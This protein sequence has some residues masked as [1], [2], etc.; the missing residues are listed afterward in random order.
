MKTGNIESRDNV[1]YCVFYGKNQPEK[2][3]IASVEEISKIREWL[4]EAEQIR[5]VEKNEKLPIIDFRK[6]VI[7]LING[8]SAQFF[9]L[10][11]NN[12][13]F[14]GLFDDKRIIKQTLLLEFIKGV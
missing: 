5:F 6:I 1:D 8:E 9:A 10:D 7:H 14:V 2:G 3:T 12:V 11:E 4:S 13:Y